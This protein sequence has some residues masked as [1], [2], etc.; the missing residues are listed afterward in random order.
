MESAFDL[1][2]NPS[3]SLFE[4][5]A[6]GVRHA[7]LAADIVCLVAG[8]GRTRRRF[9]SPSGRVIGSHLDCE[10]YIMKEAPTEAA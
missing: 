7:S 9:G 1:Q 10:D 5:F 4:E 8:V 3:D 6:L 2:E